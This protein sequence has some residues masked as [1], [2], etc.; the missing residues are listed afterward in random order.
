MLTT[1]LA[2]FAHSPGHRPSLNT[3]FE[4]SAWSLALL[5]LFR[6]IITVCWWADRNSYLFEKVKGN[7]NP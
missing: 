6:N 5:S 3:L 7:Q 4:G 2:V 1:V